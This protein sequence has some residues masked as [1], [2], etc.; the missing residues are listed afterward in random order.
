MNICVTL[1]FYNF[2]PLSRKCEDINS[3]CPSVCPSITITLSSTITFEPLDLPSTLTFEPLKV[4]LFYI[5]CTILMMK[6][7]HSYQFELWL[8]Y[9][10]TFDIC[11]NFGTI[12]CRAFTFHV[13]CAGAF[14]FMPKFFML[15]SRPLTSTYIFTNF[16]FAITF[17]PLE[18]VF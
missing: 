1:L 12:T 16:N 2:F 11:H 13:Y 4:G 7:V 5:T 3:I 9:L 6:P 8:T 14:P 18:I 17:E 10:K 15:W